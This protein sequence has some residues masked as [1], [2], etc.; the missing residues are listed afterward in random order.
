MSAFDLI[1]FDCDGV[2]I[3]SE[4]IAYQVESMLFKE[5]GA[6]ISPEEVG[7]RYSG[8]S[9]DFMLRDL[10]ENFGVTIDEDEFSTAW[11]KIFWPLALQEMKSVEGVADFINAL[12]HKMCVCSNS[13]FNHVKRGLEITGIDM[14]A[15]AHLFA[16]R[17]HGAGKPAPDVFLHAANTF[18]VE[19]A[20]C[21][22]IEDSPS[23]VKGGRAA[24]IQVAGFVGGNHCT[25][26]HGERLME[27]GAGFATHNWN[28][29][30]DFIHS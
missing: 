13:S 25:D 7:R 2:L 27:A 14:F 28:V 21:L 15:E 1:I 30:L 4:I 11:E 22:I 23:G 5:R 18:E 26:G 24:G 29:I 20:K 19:P 16:A 6:D 10:Q 12:D 8:T 9:G 17:D 3:E